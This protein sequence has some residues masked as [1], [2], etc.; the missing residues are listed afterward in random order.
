MFFNANLLDS[1]KD[2]FTLRLTPEAFY[3]Q[4]FWFSFEIAIYSLWI[5]LSYK[6]VTGYI[7]MS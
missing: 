5:F 7:D 2:S 4:S 3:D 6:I 1:P